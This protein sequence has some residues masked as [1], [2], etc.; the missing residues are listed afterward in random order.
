VKS[1]YDNA[2][3]E[4]ANLG[5]GKEISRKIEDSDLGEI[6]GRETLV[7]HLTLK[8]IEETQQTVNKMAEFV[9]DQNATNFA[10]TTGKLDGI[11]ADIAT[12]GKSLDDSAK[13]ILDLVLSST[14]SINSKADSNTTKVMEELSASSAKI[15]ERTDADFAKADKSVASLTGK[16]EKHAAG[17]EDFNKALGKNIEAII[18][19]VDIAKANTGN[20]NNRVKKIEEDVSAFESHVAS[21]FVAAKA[22]TE[23]LF[24]GLTAN[25]EG[26]FASTDKGM[27]DAFSATNAGIANADAHLKE[28]DE[29]IT[30]DVSE[31]KK[32]MIDLIEHKFEYVD[33]QFAALEGHMK[34]IE[35]LVV[36]IIKSA[37]IIAKPEM[38]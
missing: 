23:A 5:K 19:T 20:I 25:I 38:K 21:D 17:V 35:S 26:R 22:N 4:A 14:K 6:R 13:K 31:L 32:E 30:K 12:L 34:V 9:G 36:D 2:L 18:D 27:T 3:K 10:D 29:A 24:S 37:R 33:R 7:L 16:Y 11:K 28:V 1:V 8:A 15:V